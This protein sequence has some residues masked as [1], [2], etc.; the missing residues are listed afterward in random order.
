MTQTTDNAAAIAKLEATRENLLQYLN[1]Q[2][3][4]KGSDWREIQNELDRIANAV[5]ALQG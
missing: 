5:K 1:A 2:T 3:K 4:I